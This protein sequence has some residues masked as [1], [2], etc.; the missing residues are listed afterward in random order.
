MK[1]RYSF[2]KALLDGKMNADGTPKESK[3][4]EYCDMCWRLKGQHI[5]GNL[6]LPIEY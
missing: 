2:T 3:H 1:I 5:V 6:I 4:F